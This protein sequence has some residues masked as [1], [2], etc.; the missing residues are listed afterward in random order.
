MHE[1]TSELPNQSSN[2]T[3]RKFA[4]GVICIDIHL[5]SVSLVFQ[6]FFRF[7][8]KLTGSSRPTLIPLNVQVTIS[9]F[10]RCTS[11]CLRMCQGAKVET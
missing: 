11:L 8:E 7:C 4:S 1:A 3:S 6:L 2:S 9:I 5:T 10:D